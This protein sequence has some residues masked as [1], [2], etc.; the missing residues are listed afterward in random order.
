MPNYWANGNTASVKTRQRLHL[1]NTRLLLN[2]LCSSCNKNS[3]KSRRGISLAGNPAVTRG[4]DVRRKRSLAV[5]ARPDGRQ[6]VSAWP[7]CCC[8]SSLGFPLAALP[9][10]FVHRGPE[11]PVRKSVV[12]SC[13]STT[14]EAG[15][16]WRGVKCWGAGGDCFVR[17]GLRD[18]VY[19]HNR[20]FQSAAAFPQIIVFKRDKVGPSARLTQTTGRKQS[21][22]NTKHL[23]V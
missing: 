17:A 2:S 6:T 11:Q 10:I 12:P 9:L 7:V 20:T 23:N 5:R 8:C 22:V 16:W 19:V 18:D 15:S 21:A 13:R 3:R 14:R 4:G 1:C